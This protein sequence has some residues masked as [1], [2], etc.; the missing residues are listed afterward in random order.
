MCG[1][2]PQR[3]NGKFYFLLQSLQ[4]AQ[5]EQ[6][7]LQVCSQ[8]RMLWHLPEGFRTLF[9]P[10]CSLGSDQLLGGLDAFKRPRQT[11]AATPGSLTW[12]VRSRSKAHPYVCEY[13][14]P[15]DW[16]IQRRHALSSLKLSE[17]WLHL[18]KSGKA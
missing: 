9:T 18:L 15:A 6:V 11:T 4:E 5:A 16:N 10:F 7:Y 3:Y 8:E 2:L 12:R 14:K 1:E 13:P 17:G